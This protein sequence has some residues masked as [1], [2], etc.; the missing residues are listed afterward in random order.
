MTR[1]RAES[2][3]IILGI[4]FTLIFI[5]IIG[6]YFLLSGEHDYVKAAEQQQ[7]ITI[8]VDC[9]DGGIYDRNM[10]PLVNNNTTYKA[11]CI[12]QAVDKN[13][14]AKFAADKAEFEKLYS[15]GEPFIFE[16]IEEAEENDGLTVFSVPQRYSDNQIAQ[17]VIGYTS[18]GTGADG[19]EFAYDNVLR[20]D[21]GSN[22]VTY[23]IDGFGR[24]LIGDGKKVSRYGT[25]EQGIVT[26]LDSNIQRI[27]ENAGKSIQKGAVVVSHVETGDILALASFPSYSLNN[28]DEA[29]NSPD[30][31][32]INRT[33]YSYSVGSIFKLV[34]A[35]EAIQEQHSGYVYSCNGSINVSGKNFNCHKLDGHGTQSMTDAIINSCNTY[36][37]DISRLLNIP[38]LRATAFSLGFGREIHLCS[39][40]TASA[41]VLP[42]VDE[43]LIPA[44]LANFS[45]GQ[46]RLTASPLQISQMTCA[47]ANNGKMPVLRLIKGFTDDGINISD[48]KSPQLAYAMDENTAGQLQRMM[49]AAV[50]E[51]K[52]SNAR[53]RLTTAGAKTSTAQTG[54]TDENGSELYNAW[55]TGF[56][57][58]DAPEYAVTVLVEDG[59]YGNDE[60]APVFREIAD[61][62]TEYSIRKKQ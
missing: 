15:K 36:F 25:P 56:F 13:K 7:E 53:P 23:N 55:I 50:S 43:L 16:C 18:E 46:G 21:Y 41:G 48:E 44:E 33:L 31:P 49:N 54:R 12:P 62:I 17:H 20:A 1:K 57:P 32:M 52:D 11:V 45:F 6:N 29:V 26:T 61:E 51:N 37:I 22:S 9:G 14:T 24:V 39:G 10:K 47:I 5:I 30:S 19:I 4:L 2:G 35:C 58:V 60:A 3:I 27:C 40:M 42:T 38:D 34:I 59:G 28:F 8:N